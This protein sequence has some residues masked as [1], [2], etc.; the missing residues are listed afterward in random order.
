MIPAGGAPCHV[1][2]TVSDESPSTAL[3]V[4]FHTKNPAPAVVYYDTVSH[5]GQNVTAYPF[6]KTGYQFYMD[7]IDEPRW[8]HWVDLTNLTAST[9]Y[10]FAVGSASSPSV[11]KRVRT[12]PDGDTFTFVAGTFLDVRLC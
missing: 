9:T 4:N 10:Y 11:E 5:A 3:I 7:I 12:A 8:V 2:V 1:Y 6:T